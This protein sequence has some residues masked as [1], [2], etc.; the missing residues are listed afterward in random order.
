MGY[1]GLG[2]QSWIT[3]L[4]PQ[5]FLSKRSKQDGGGM[6]K[7]FG[8]EVKDYYHLKHRDL[9]RLLEKEGSEEYKKQLLKTL[10]NEKRAVLI[11][12]ILVYIMYRSF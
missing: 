5:K 6:E 9:K 11:T 10:I 1:M 2:M 4:K 7:M 3:R 12:N 8:I